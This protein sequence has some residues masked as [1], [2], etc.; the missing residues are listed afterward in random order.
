M[1]PKRI[2]LVRHGESEGNAEGTS[3]ETVPDYGLYLTEKGKEQARR[4]GHE[5]NEL[6]G[7]ESIYSYIS[8]FHRTRQTFAQIESVLGDKNVKVIEDPRIREQD[9]GNLRSFEEEKKI[10]IE[11]GEYGIFYFHIKDGESGANVFDR[12]STFFETVH[13]DFKKPDYP[14]NTLVVTHGVTLRVLL[15]RVLNWSV[16]E[17]ES[18]DNPKNCELYI[19]EQN[20]KGDY[21]LITPLRKESDKPA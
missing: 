18:V 1:K 16:E 19:L 5:I 7:T 2:I 21:E 13:R 3:Y 20:D 10:M 4:A 11:R 8:P 17:F 9:W 15:M 12:T 6:I 14:Q